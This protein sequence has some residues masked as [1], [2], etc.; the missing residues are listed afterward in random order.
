MLSL[1][2]SPGCDEALNALQCKLNVLLIG[3]VAA[4]NMPFA[5]GT[6]CGAGY[7]RHFFFEE[8]FLGEFFAAQTG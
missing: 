6:K 1:P 4:T 7:Y 3:G 8:K 5:A 2:G